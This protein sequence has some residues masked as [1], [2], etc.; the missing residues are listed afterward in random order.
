MTSNNIAVHP[1]KREIITA[2]CDMASYGCSQS[3]QTHCALRAFHLRAPSTNTSVWP[4]EFLEI[5]APLRAAL[6]FYT[7]HLAP[8]GFGLFQSPQTYSYL[9]SP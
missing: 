7:R 2:G 9:A 5:D 3:A 8:Y 1:A 6:R 4:G